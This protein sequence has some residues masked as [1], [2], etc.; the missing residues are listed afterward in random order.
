VILT[1]LRLVRS[2]DA[3]GLM[4]PHRQ[5]GLRARASSSLRTAGLATIAGVIFALSFAAPASA[6]APPTISKAFG[7][8]SILVGGS[9]SLSF[10]IINP[11]TSTSL[12]GVTFADTM[13]SGLVISTPNGL[14]GP[15]G[16]G[17]ITAIAGSGSV[18]LSSA[19]LAP[20]AS[21]T[22]SVNVTG[23][24]FGVQHNVT[25]VIT[26]NEGGDNVGAIADLAVTAANSTITTVTSSQNPSVFGQ[27]VTFTATVLG[28]G[29]TPT[30]TVTFNDGATTLGT[31]MLSGGHAS[32][33]TSALAV[34]SNH[35]IAANY[36]GDTN[37]NASSGVLNSNQV[38]NKA[39]TTTTV[40]SS[41]NPSG[42]GQPVT[43]TA[44]VSV[45]SPGSG[46]PTGTVTFLDGGTSIGTG[47]V[48]GGIASFTTSALTIGP[49]TITASYPGDSN[50][51]ASAGPLTGNPQV[52]GKSATAT[53]VTSSANPSA[54]GQAVTFTATVSGAGGTPTGTVTFLD[55]GTSIGTGTLSGGVASFTT[56]TLAVGSHS[57]TTSYAGD[58]SFSGSTGTLTGNPQVV[59]KAA[60]STTLTSS[61]NP[62]TLGQA[63]TFTA[64]V[65]GSGGTP[66]GTVT[67]LDGGISIGTGTL[68]GG[69]A[70]FTTSALAV[71]NHTITTS[72]PGDGNFGASTGALVGNPQVVNK[73]ATTT[74][75]TSSQNPS[76]FGQTVTFT[77]T[78]TGSGGT[79]TGIVTFLD[80]GTAIGT[81]TLSGGVATFATSTL[82]VG[83]H[84][85][86]TSYP[87]DGNFTVSTG[88]LA[89]NPQV[90]NK[91]ATTTTLTS[92][93]NP[94]AFGQ[95]VT[96]TA[97]VS[98]GG[99]TPTGTVTF[100]DGGT[101]IGT[102]ILS[103]GVATFATSELSAG[104]H[105][106]T[107]SYPGDVNFGA[108]TGAL[109]S[110]PQVVNKGATSTTL[111]SS[112]N[113]SAFGQA[114]AFTATVK[115]A[116]GTPTGTVTF[117]DNGN[118]IGTAK[119]NAS[120]TATLTVSS[121]AVGT[122][123]ITASYGGDTDFTAS[124]SAVLVQSV[125]V[126]PDS[127]RLR[128]MQIA[129]TPVIAQISGQAI[130]GAID[131]AIAAGFSGNPKIMS[132]NGSGF[133]YYFGGDTTPAQTS[134]SADESLKRFLASPADANVRVDDSFRAL[135]YAGPVKAPPPN[136][137][138][139]Q[140]R[141]WLA[142]IDF[143]GT[144]FYRGTVGDDMKGTQV[145]VVAGLTHLIT[146]NFLVG[147]LGGYE[148]FDYS[149]QAFNGVLKGRWLDHRRLFGLAHRGQ[150]AFRC[151]SGVVG[152]S[153]GQCF[154]H[155]DR[156]LYRLTLAHVQRT[157]GDLRL[158]TLHGRT[159][160]AGLRA[161]GTRDRLYRQSRYSPAGSQL[162]DRAR[163]RWHQGEL[164]LSVVGRRQADALR[165]PLC[166]LLF[167]GRQCPDAGTDDRASAAR[168][169]R[170]G[171]RGYGGDIP[172]R[173]AAR[174]RQRSERPRQPDPHLDL[175]GAREGPV[176]MWRR[177]CSW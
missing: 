1:L 78:V 15:C 145:N 109:T 80:A 147:A 110:N 98:G 134:E 54:S 55:G 129:A 117:K 85:I 43:F 48:S 170:A 67:F 75:L 175:D 136:A 24:G 3:A 70:S 4:R 39:S 112:Q 89:N 57:I 84:T 174:R 176:L 58:G 118:T 108:S 151:I 162:R 168:L 69:V 128:E 77:A 17:T 86:T 10:T 22:F 60:T 106:I 27:S 167:L 157:D 102:G 133:T 137:S 64:T 50:F 65:S 71:G 99:G 49:H 120:G 121:L 156:Q 51:S 154:R 140:P 144:D 28:T 115:G 59:T 66:T 171:D 169:G 95:P 101:A 97:T 31:G 123:S 94:S 7:A 34:G 41:A 159:V 104:N 9:T 61:K 161:M 135:G 13:P 40:T 44:T 18:S 105:T 146:P 35:A 139:A 32:F 153:C 96:F 79:P 72:Y 21:C 158:A 138:L 152:H 87:G 113:P 56:S 33:T 107:T 76:A 81:G 46:S 62:S 148:H 122:H 127:I 82:S 177:R 149:S 126:S 124:T 88:A 103:G 53:V 93:Q 173:R 45:N 47:T 12:T 119:L 16:G 92:S 141:D 132:P 14:T 19:T 73:G 131:S 8:S 165:G 11:N 160:G 116:G 30:G 29:G 23:T 25:S 6:Q 114:V 130:S 111:T 20:S 155:R 36:S 172:Q 164:S 52:V 68:S 90:I 91:G 125:S 74:T 166:R 83:S 143:R 38:V 63:V 100:L 42:V 142:W 26:S 2:W 37:F 163:Q 5:V 150:P